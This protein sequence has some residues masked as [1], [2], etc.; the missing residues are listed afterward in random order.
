MSAAIIQLHGQRQA[1]ADDKPALGDGYTRIVN[2]VMKA[3]PKARLSAYELA[4]CLAIA[5]RTFG[6]NKGKDR[7][8]ASQL[9]GDMDITRPKAS[10]ILNQLLRKNVVIREGG[11]HGPIK[12]NTCTDQW[13]RPKKATRAPENPNAYP[14]Q[15]QGNENGTVYPNRVRNT[16]PNRGHSRDKRQTNS[17][18]PHYLSGQSTG[19][20]KVSMPSN[21]PEKKPKPMKPGA[22]VQSPNGRQWGEQIDV[23]LADLMASTIDSRLGQDAPAKRNMLTWAN[24]IRLM[25]EQ[26]KRPADAIRALFAWS[27]QDQFWRGNI[28]SPAKL[29]L[30][31]STLAAQRNEDRKKREG[32]SHETR[33]SGN[34]AS[35]SELSRQQTD[36]QYAIDNF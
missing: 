34:R 36:I 17:N 24:E 13:L 26:D 35:Q 7:I 30:Q 32:G 3:W 6:F 9:A 29:R 14:N 23:D 8:A 4:M 20:D 1:M 31:W 15:E 18:A 2:D 28:L 21:P 25:R 27:Q 22:V 19:R 12:I 33:R 11:S 5:Q 16:Y 10:K